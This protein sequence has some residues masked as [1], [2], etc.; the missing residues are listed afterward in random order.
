MRADGWNEQGESAGF[1][2]QV[3]SK[4]FDSGLNMPQ[5]VPLHEIRLSI[6]WTTG[7]RPGQMDLVTLLPQRKPQPGEVMR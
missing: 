4:L 1:Q 2:W 7:S 3:R 6:Q 5:A